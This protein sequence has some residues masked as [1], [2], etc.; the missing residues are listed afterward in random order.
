M[1]DAD[2]IGVLSLRRRR[3]FQFLFQYNCFINVAILEYNARTK[4]SSRGVQKEER[5]SPG[6][7]LW[8]RYDGGFG[9][10]TVSFFICWLNLGV[11]SVSIGIGNA[12]L[13]VLNNRASPLKNGLALN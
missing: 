9:G 12:K 13:F 4:Q 8:G 7:F 5:E 11:F 6:E 3:K 1:H 10:E 2:G